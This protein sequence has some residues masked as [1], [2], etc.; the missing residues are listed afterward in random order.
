MLDYVLRELPHHILKCDVLLQSEIKVL[1]QKWLP[2]LDTTKIKSLQ[3]LVPCKRFNK[4]DQTI[5]ICD[6]LIS[7]D[8]EELQALILPHQVSKVSESHVIERVP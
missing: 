6:V 1:L 4:C 3:A 2:D 7:R 5:L 8:I